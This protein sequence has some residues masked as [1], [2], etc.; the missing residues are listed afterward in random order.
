VRRRISRSLSVFAGLDNL[1]GRAYLVALT[2]YPNT[3]APRYWRLGL[4]WETAAQ[5]GA[6]ASKPRAPRT[7]PAPSTSPDSLSPE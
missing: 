2:P 4:R 3:G 6:A 5:T 1:L 7:S